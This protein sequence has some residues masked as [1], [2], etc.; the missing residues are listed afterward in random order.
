MSAPDQHDTNAANSDAP[1][2]SND[3]RMGLMSHLKELRK[4]L[5]VCLLA[6]C[7]AF[8][9]TYSFSEYI[10]GLL[11][12]PLL[13]SLPP[14][15]D[16]MAFAGVVE[17]FF[18][19]LKAAIVAAIILASPVIL[20]EV[21]GFVAP[22]LYKDERRWF[23]PVVVVSTL[24]F[25]GGVLFA[26][27]IVFPFGFKFLLGFAGDDMRPF[28]SMGLY[29]SFATKLLLAFGVVFEMPLFS[30]VLTRLGI[31]NGPML[32]RGWKYALFLA[33]VVGALLTPPD[34]VSQ[35]LMA[36]PIMVLYGISI[37]VSYVFKRK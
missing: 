33:V 31:V 21:W 17:P 8:V 27:R 12:M 4:R 16:F 36:G 29:F 34:V 14:E 7:A 19:Y 13:D 30:L 1:P 26:H 5:I 18:T 10:Y 9:L 6:V 28:L 35:A 15:N 20:Y 24:M 3:D 37:I 22:G 11:A 2:G 23:V 25:A 32:L